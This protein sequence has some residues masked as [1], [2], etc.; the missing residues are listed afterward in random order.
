MMSAP[1]L[2]CCPCASCR[3]PRHACSHWPY[4]CVLAL[5]HTCWVSRPWE[6]TRRRIRAA[7]I[8]IQPW[9]PSSYWCE[10]AVKAALVCG[11][12]LRWSH[13][14]LAVADTAI[15]PPHAPMCPI[16]ATLFQLLQQF[17]FKFSTHPQVS[18]CCSVLSVILSI[19]IDKHDQTSS[20]IAFRHTTATAPG[21]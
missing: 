21:C 3:A 19:L 12:L 2:V 17:Q 8:A 5:V 7:S 4:V 10:Q 20:P 14:L 11:W 16:H 6:L 1:S 9:L 18:R 15:N 13:Q